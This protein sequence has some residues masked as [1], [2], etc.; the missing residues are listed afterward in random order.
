MFEFSPLV[1]HFDLSLNTYCLSPVLI[2]EKQSW[3]VRHKSSL[4][5]WLWRHASALSP[6]TPTWHCRPAQAGRRRL[7]PRVQPLFEMDRVSSAQPLDQ[8]AEDSSEPGQ[9]F[10]GQSEQTMAL[11][12]RPFLNQKQHSCLPLDIYQEYPYK[13]YLFRSVRSLPSRCSRDCRKFIYIKVKQWLS[14]GFKFDKWNGKWDFTLMWPFE[15]WKEDFTQITRHI[16][17]TA[18]W[19]N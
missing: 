12:V 6:N 3:D 15:M 16:S 14:S 9:P 1:N 8:W 11:N 4:L 10:L 2:E 13:E 18:S 19:N 17:Y 5:I 7:L